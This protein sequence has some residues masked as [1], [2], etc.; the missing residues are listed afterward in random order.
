MLFLR[1]YLSFLLNI[2]Y[3]GIKILTCSVVYVCVI[4]PAPVTVLF[5]SVVILTSKKSF[6]NLH[7]YILILNTTKRLIINCTYCY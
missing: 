5:F 1:Q 4:V 2:H 3:N 6:W 7:G